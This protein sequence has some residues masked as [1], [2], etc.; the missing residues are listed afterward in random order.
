MVTCASSRGKACIWHQLSLKLSVDQ[1]LSAPE[2]NK[3]ANTVVRLDCDVTIGKAVPQH[4]H[5]WDSWG[6]LS[7]PAGHG[8][9]HPSVVGQL[10]SSDSLPD[11]QPSE[12]CLWQCLPLLLGDAAFQGSGW[13]DSSSPHLGWRN[14]W[15]AGLEG[16]KTWTWLFK[17]G[18][19]RI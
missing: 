16:G 19:Y 4:T 6:K 14:A 3:Q 8:P 9:Q 17:Q 11:P 2:S 5:L 10:W 1:Q 12:T 13:P 18:K 7:L 15:L